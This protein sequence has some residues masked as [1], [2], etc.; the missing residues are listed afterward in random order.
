MG[1]T[2]SSSSKRTLRQRN[3]Q[4]KRQRKR[5]TQSQS[6]RRVSKVSSRGSSRRRLSNRKKGRKNRR[7]NKQE[8]GMERF[9]EETV[10]YGMKGRWIRIR[11]DI[12]VRLGLYSD[13][14]PGYY[15]EFIPKDKKDQKDPGKCLLRLSLPPGHIS[16]ETVILTSEVASPQEFINKVDEAIQCEK[17]AKEMEKEIDKARQEAIQRLK[18]SRKMAATR[19]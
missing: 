4:R 13:D 16:S 3:R 11:Y 2:R 8:G 1:L 9:L 5:R 19:G 14:F 12:G 10:Y 18:E 7:K 6:K 15:Y 17:N